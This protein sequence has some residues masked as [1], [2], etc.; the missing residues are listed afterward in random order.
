MTR[1]VIFDMDGTLVD[2]CG[3]CVDILSAMLRERGSD[4]LIDIDFARPFMS[5]GGERMV[6]ALLG[7]ACGDPSVELAEFRA[8]YEVTVTPVQALFAGVADSLARLKDSD[9]TM[10][11]CSNKPQNLCEQ[12]V[13]DTGLADFFDVIVGRRPGLQPKPA[14]DLVEATLGELGATAEECLFVGDSAL[15]KA[16]ADE[17]GMPFVFLTYGYA[18]DGWEPSDSDQFDCFAT[19]TGAIVAH[20]EEKRGRQTRDG[21]GFALPWAAEKGRAMRQSISVRV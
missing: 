18:E 21:D 15:D 4:H 3:L 7:P 8:R 17:A 5:H 19:M 20:I 6:S 1:Y 16:V 12:V 13:E 14:P 9:V 2:S 11:I 10:A